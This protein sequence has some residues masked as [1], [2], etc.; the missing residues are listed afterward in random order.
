M[1][2]DLYKGT[3]LCPWPGDRARMLDMERRLRPVRAVTFATL[4]ITLASA[5]TTLGWWP[6]A[7]LTLAVIAFAVL[8]RGLESSSKPEYRLATA[9]LLS[10]GMIAMSIAL[11][12]GQD[13]PALAWLVI[14]AVTLPARF[15]RRGIIAGATVTVVALL[16]V[17][18]GT[19][20]AEV[21]GDFSRT[22]ST[23]S[24]I[25]CVLVLSTALMGSD[26][27]HRAEAVID[28]LTGMLNRSALAVRVAELTQQARL[29]AQPVALIVVD[30]DR[31][32]QLNDLHGH[33]KGDA[34]LVEV[35]SRIRGE[36]RAYDAAYRLGGDEFLIVL[37]GAG[38]APAAD[39]AEALCRSVS[40]DQVQELDVTVSIGVSTSAEGAFDYGEVVERADRALYE[41]KAGGRNR[42]SCSS[43]LHVA[44]DEQTIAA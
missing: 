19:A 37:P 14:P 27:E 17:T 22:V 25:I 21:A 42:V 41:A 23:L 15:G 13:S 3:W 36:L 30:I 5:G 12:G 7:P 26:L 44:G 2:D 9:W 8:G 39:L 28:P 43:G 16:L 24:L 4:G 40:L 1:R 29:S 32:K 34:V 18:A 33:P 38:L 11:T 31:F 10:Q 20:P 35:A 6:L